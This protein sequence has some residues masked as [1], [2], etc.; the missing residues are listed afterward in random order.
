MVELAAETGR[1]PGHC[2]QRLQTV[3]E[4][5]N[6]ARTQSGDPLFAFRLHQFL[7]SGSSVYA[8]LGV[9]S[10]RELTM[11]GRYE[12]DSGRPLFP[13]AFCRECG[14]EH[15]V[16]AVT[17]DR[18]QRRLVPGPARVG[19][20]DEDFRG[21]SGYLTLA[22][23]DQL[24]RG[25]ME[26]LPDHWQSMRVSGTSIRERYREHVPMKLKVAEDGQISEEGSLQAYLQARPLMLCRRCRSTWTLR[27]TNDFAKLSSLS[28]TGRSTAATVAVNALVADLSGQ[29]VPK[30][31]R[32]V[33]SFT[34]NVQDAAL[35]SGHLNDFVQTV[36]LRGAIV[37]ALDRQGQLEYADLGPALLEALDPEPSDYL[38]E[39]PAGSRIP[40]GARRAMWRMLSHLAVADLGQGWRIAHPNLEQTGL[41][42]I[43]YTGIEDAVS[44]DEHWR[45]VGPMQT[46]DLRTR[47]AV[48]TAFLD[49][50]RMALC[51]DASEL[52]RDEIW[53]IE[54]DSQQWLRDPWQAE[55]REL[56]LGS[57]A[58]L[59]GNQRSVRGRNRGMLSLGYRSQ[60]GRYLRD[61]RTFDP[62]ASPTTA[63][64]ISGAEAD[65]LT[66]AIVTALRG[67]VLTMNSGRVQIKAAA[68]RWEKGNGRAPASNPVRSRSLHLRRSHN[69][70]PSEFFSKLYRLGARSLS[71]MLAREHTGQVASVDRA[72]REE[73]FRAGTLPV[74]FCTPTMELGVDI[75]DLSAVHLRNIPPTPANYAQR[76]GRAGRGG[77]P[78]LIAGYAA[79][80]NAH[81]RYF[82]DNR[83][84]M[85]HGAMAPARFDLCNQELLQAHIHSLWLTETGMSLGNSINEILDLSETVNLPLKPHVREQFDQLQRYPEAAVAAANGLARRI[86]DL[87]KT[88]WFRP[89]W[90]ESVIRLAPAEF[91]RAFN[92]WR[93]LYR[94]AISA[95]A[96]AR[97][98]MDDPNLDRSK[99]DQA[100]RNHD[101][102][103]R[104]IQ[105]LQN[106]LSY[107]ESDFYPYRYLA[108]EGF[109]PGYNFPRLPVRA[110]VR[111]RNESRS[112]S[113]GRFIGIRD[114]GPQN[115]IYYEG[116]RH[117]VTGAM[118]PAGDL[119]S[120][121]E[122]ARA[123]KRCGF[124]HPGE[125]TKGERCEYCNAAFSQ[126]Q[127]P[128]LAQ[129]IPQPE[130]RTRRV[131]RIGSEEE[132]RVRTGYKITTHFRFDP[133]RLERVGVVQGS[134]Q[135][136]VIEYASAAT[137]WRINRGWRR[138]DDRDGFFLDPLTYDWIGQPGGL[139]QQDLDPSAPAPVSGVMPFVRETRNLLLLGIDVESDD[140]EKVLQTL[141]YAIKLGIQLEFQ[142]ESRELASELI[143][144]DDYRRL[145]FFEAAEGGIGVCEQILS[146]NGLAR[147]AARALQICHFD[148]N[149]EEATGEVCSAAC[150]RCLL[151]YE[152]QWVHHLLD[153]RV[154]REHLLRLADS[155]L[156]PQ[157]SDRDRRAHFEHLLRLVDSRSRL[158]R[159]FLE[160]LFENHLKLPNRAHFR[161]CK[162]I[163]AEP[164]F[165]YESSHACI[166]V[167]GSVHERADVKERDQ[168]VRE[169][170]EDRGFRVIAIGPN[171]RASIETWPQV[172]GSLPDR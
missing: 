83:D 6:A 150:Y 22:G 161:P 126:E 59:P 103:R 75:S 92:R 58:G 106:Q 63:A 73:S 43:T 70:L 39:T 13:L 139:D 100:E 144:E 45:D 38:R 121:S 18:D 169:Q 167:D 48:L 7:S 140:K 114:Y 152:N 105:A 52:D 171:L 23:D 141:L 25:D 30:G 170:L 143:G 40:E 44:S 32:K 101:D 107:A 110:F 5:G 61:P 69:F 54:R 56:T 2:R 136:A 148:E 132:V 87:E 131:R 134:E 109:L 91:D 155:A 163:Y 123:C 31:Q 35:Q 153:R 11:D 90:A 68:L 9:G 28:Q 82:F 95:R 10:D 55:E 27:Q 74:L 77:T 49:H 60:W 164:D 151:A 113:R 97:L 16:V 36:Q 53:R 20:P 119:N 67:N 15:Y 112:L 93:Q 81:D 120:I 8:T 146:G 86:P 50:L 158:E 37:G 165:Y 142:V 19:A 168:H 65:Q 21:D 147:V 127:A 98:V 135:M 111:T 129:L 94:S 66:E 47:L 117:R 71:G 125:A 172:F 3:L 162:D 80:G 157:V 137:I 34:D 84:Q 79:Q 160:Y 124:I 116:H 72:E 76:S 64:R 159:N 108:A 118:I 166:F 128:Y 57:H 156:V 17:S 85:I 24:W 133:T 12:S 4:A 115:L 138:S 104:Q 26:D 89:D 96:Q 1:N 99:V 88:S 14:L 62:G 41:L 51:I 154:I 149:G 42:K 122:Q 145:M 29:D 78:A 130:A 46:A 33:L 102:A